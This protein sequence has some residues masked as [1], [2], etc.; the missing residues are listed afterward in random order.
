MIYHN[1][2]VFN[3]ILL[4]VDI[5]Q[6]LINI[7]YI[8]SILFYFNRLGFDINQID[9]SSSLNYIIYTSSVY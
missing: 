1:F 8:F 7:L 4:I 2:Q 6:E 9:N 5:F 3:Y